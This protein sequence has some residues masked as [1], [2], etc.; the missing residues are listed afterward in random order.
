MKEENFISIHYLR[1]I[2]AILVVAYHNKQ[3]LNNVYAESNLGDIFFRGGAFGVDLF[4]MISGFIIALSTKKENLSL[5]SFAIKRFFRIYP[6]FAFCLLTL[7]IINPTYNINDIVRSALLIG[8]NYSEPAPFFGYNILFPAWTLTYEIYFYG[9]FLFS[10]LISHKHRV[11]LSSLI[12]ISPSIIL[13][14]IF[15]GNISF[16]SN[17]KINFNSSL[18]IG[19]LNFISSPM[20]FE[21]VIGMLIYKSVSLLELIKNK[22]YISFL[23]ISLF[24]CLYLYGYRYDF[25][26]INFGIWAACL[27]VGFLLLEHHCK[28]KENNILSKLGDI[29]YS[30]YLVHAIV[31][32]L[33]I[34]YHSSIPMYDKDGIAKFMMIISLSIFISLYVHKYVEV[35]FIN[36][37]KSLISKL[38]ST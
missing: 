20:L 24:I 17:M 29:S 9:A 8:T 37:G 16:E 14:M 7:C 36:I 38:R 22:K 28:L 5:I 1:G 15:N 26:P 4:F 21:F 30:L 10:M 2:A 35:P 6:L 12:L 33:L 25:G 34:K 19:P 31:M 23:L 27:L 13:Q 11:L 3:Y 18:P 32:I